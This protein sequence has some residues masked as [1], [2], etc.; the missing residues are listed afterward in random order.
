MR[1]RI[2]TTL[3]TLGLG[4][5]AACSGESS[6]A[7]FRPGT[8]EATSPKAWSAAGPAK[9]LTPICP[10]GTIRECT[11]RGC[12]C[13][14][15]QTYGLLGTIEG[16]LP[17]PVEVM[18]DGQRS[19]GAS[20]SLYYSVFQNEGWGC[21]V[22]S[23]PPNM[24]CVLS[25]SSGTAPQQLQFSVS[26]GSA[27]AIGGTVS[28]LGPNSG[29]QPIGLSLYDASGSPL[30]TAQLSAN[31]PYTFPTSLSNGQT[32]HA[33]VTSQPTGSTCSVAN[34]SGTA[35]GIHAI[36][37]VN[38][39]C[40]PDDVWTPVGGS[41]LG[42]FTTAMWVMQ[43]GTVLA[44]QDDSKTLWRLTPDASG[45]YF[46]GVWSKA[47]SFLV[48]KTFFASQVLSNGKLATCGGE[49]SGN[50]GETNYCEIFDPQ[51]GLSTTLT[52][53]TNGSTINWG[54]IGDSPSVVL[55]DGRWFLGNTNGFG[56]NSA[57][58][59]PVALTWSFVGGDQDNEQGYALLQDG[60]VISAH[61]YAEVSRRYS[62]GSPGFVDESMPVMLGAKFSTSN[63]P[64]QEIGPSMSLMDGRLIWFGATGHT[65]IY[66]ATTAGQAG[67]WNVGPDLPG[68]LN[69]AGS[70]LLSEDMPALLEP[71]GRVLLVV[72]DQIGTTEQFA[73]FDPST[74]GF[75]FK[76]G[77][78]PTTSAAPAGNG[79]N[80]LLLPNGQ[81]LVSMKGGRLYMVT[82]AG[83]APASP[84]ILG[85]PS[86]VTRDTTVA[87]T[88][89]QLCGLSEVSMYG[90]DNQ[91]AENYP[92]VRVVSPL[93]TRYLRA[94]DVST[95]SIAPNARSTVMVDI[96]SDLP[97]GSYS[98][99]V[100]AMGTASP[101]YT[102]NL[103]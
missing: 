102:I 56:G 95:R 61:P 75:A 33:I 82:F 77:S 37:N 38:V 100:I 15:A 30:G 6:S 103:Q 62:V 14:K 47:G 41:P 68:F 70:Q 73:E 13:V 16:V 72:S 9:T 99:Q 78:F 43:D 35:D 92:I 50:G 4:L 63:G 31:G 79:I 58:L 64:S 69:G 85:F 83:G 59:D 32:Y 26:C 5:I 96:P 46:N 1:N 65:A 39:A 2:R 80:M 40:W 20:G 48:S 7:P 84:T 97:P 24:A 36:S 21:A 76:S 98:L 19:A 55:P 67:T 90:D 51:A 44:L 53:P 29:G 94:H 86:T 52:P 22:V 91:Q 45:S 11:P 54:S 81:A 60:D 28:G 10:V 74:T 8:E 23:A 101:G 88:G 87:L 3:T 27:S 93:R 18:C 66:T 57:I 71:T 34:A 12:T 49:Y 17:S 25:P 42:D 89:L